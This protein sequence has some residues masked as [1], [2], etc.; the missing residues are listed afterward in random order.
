[1]LYFL[2]TWDPLG[3]VLKTPHGKPLDPDCL[4]AC[5]GGVKV[6]RVLWDTFIPPFEA[7]ELHVSV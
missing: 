1:M 3:R 5:K 6:G 7:S 4:E 2:G